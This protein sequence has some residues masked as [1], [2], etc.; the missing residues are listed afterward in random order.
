[1][2]VPCTT[3]AVIAPELK[4]AYAATVAP[5]APCAGSLHMN[6][7][8]VDKRRSE[9]FP[10]PVKFA[11]YVSSLCSRLFFGLA[12]SNEEQSNNGKGSTFAN[13]YFKNNTCVFLASKQVVNY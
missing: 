7:S 13:K 3:F 5:S 8:N 2:F 6:V 10:I 12:F 4:D 9:K 1:M 11:E